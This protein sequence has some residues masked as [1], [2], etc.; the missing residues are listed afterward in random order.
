MTIEVMKIGYTIHCIYKLKVPVYY[1][2]IL[3]YFSE[4]SYKF[5]RWNIWYSSTTTM[6]VDSLGKIA[7]SANPF[8][9]KSKL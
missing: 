7:G 6:P 4:Q 1:S 9:G 2:F 3:F 8:T 5:E